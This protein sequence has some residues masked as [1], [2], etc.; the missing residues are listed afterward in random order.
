[1]STG[2]PVIP[3]L[4]VREAYPEDADTIIR[5]QL[6][7]ARESEGLSLD[8]DILRKGVD[9]VFKD[10]QLGFY[11]VAELEEKIIASLMVTYE[12]SDWRNS[13]VAWLQSLYVLPDYRRR[14]VFKKMYSRLKEIAGADESLSGIRLYVDNGNTVAQEAYRS[15]GMDGDHYRVFE[16]LKHK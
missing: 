7:M 16:W 2:Y 14:G 12:W 1:M 9:A 5:F 4:T 8:E 15:I 11:L 6:A 13:R 10:P 3:G